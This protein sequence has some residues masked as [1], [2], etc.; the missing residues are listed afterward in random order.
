MEDDHKK[1][2]DFEI[3]L[4]RTGLIHQDARKRLADLH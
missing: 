1:K 3:F 2:K 4:S